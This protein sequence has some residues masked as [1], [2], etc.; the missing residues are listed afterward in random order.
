MNIF[1]QIER[2][3]LE[4]DM[5]CRELAIFMYENSFDSLTELCKKR[6]EELLD[7]QRELFKL[8]C[9]F[10]KEEISKLIEDLDSYVIDWRL[11]FATGELTYQL[12]DYYKS[13]DVDEIIKDGFEVDN[14][15]LILFNIR[16]KYREISMDKEVLEEKTLDL[17]KKADARNQHVRSLDESL[18]N[19]QI[20]WNYSEDFKSMKVGILND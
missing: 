3:S 5:K 19:R 4:I 12:Y 10:E 17:Y 8:K 2:I 13:F 11:T 1:Q 9:K 7:K 14:E 16:N 18:N 15:L 6:Y 20:I